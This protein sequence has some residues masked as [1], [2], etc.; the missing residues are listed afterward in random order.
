MAGPSGASNPGSSL[1]LTLWRVNGGAASA[2]TSGK[3][4]AVTG[5]GL[6]GGG[7]RSRTGGAAAGA[8]AAA[9]VATVPRLTELHFVALEGGS[10]VVP[11]PRAGLDR[12]PPGTVPALLPLFFPGLRAV[13]PPVQVRRGHISGSSDF[14]VSVVCVS[15]ALFG[16]SPA[17]LPKSRHH[18]FFSAVSLLWRCACD[19]LRPVDFLRRSRGEPCRCNIFQRCTLHHCVTVRFALQVVFNAPGNRLAVLDIAGGVTLVETSEDAANASP[20]GRR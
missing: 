6:G 8:A 18:S 11:A 7:A 19:N 13:A 3:E 9:S 20:H 17:R 5:A 16:I 12:A 15:C 1:S 4:A 2:V 14:P 10:L